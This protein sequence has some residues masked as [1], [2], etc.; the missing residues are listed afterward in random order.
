MIKLISKIETLYSAGIKNYTSIS[1]ELDKKS[2]MESY[3]LILDNCSKIMKYFNTET[4]TRVRDFRHRKFVKKTTEIQPSCVY[5][6]S[7]NFIIEKDNKYC[8]NCGCR[9][10]MF[11]EEDELSIHDDASTISSSSGGKRQQHVYYKPNQFMDFVYRIMG[12]S[13]KFYIPDRYAAIIRKDVA[14]NKIEFERDPDKFI[15]DLLYKLGIYY[16][17]SKEIPD[18]YHMA[19]GKPYLK[20]DS[21]DMEMIKRIYIYIYESKI[22]NE[23]NQSIPGGKYML[24]RLMSLLGIKYDGLK[25]GFIK[26]TERRWGMDMKWARYLNYIKQNPALTT[27]ITQHRLKKKHKTVD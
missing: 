22:R 9:Y 21:D 11:S 6:G 16:E 8:I 1:W 15:T 4:F 24:K 25:I 18:I 27:M 7:T 26:E 3:S 17:Y 5:C 10:Q 14:E 20:I 13:N 12:S 19:T 23:P 2:M